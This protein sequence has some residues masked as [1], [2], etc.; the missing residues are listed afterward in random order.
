MMTYSTGARAKLNKV[1]PRKILQLLLTEKFTSLSRPTNNHLLSTNLCLKMTKPKK[2]REYILFYSIGFKNEVIER[3][4]NSLV[5]K[6]LRSNII[7][8]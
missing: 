7:K 2:N 6:C 8:I 4:V 1:T 3:Y 5:F